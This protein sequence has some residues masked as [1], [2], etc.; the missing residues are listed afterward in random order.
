M[1]HDKGNTSEYLT[2][3]TI[4]PWGGVDKRKEGVARLE[5][6]HACAVFFPVPPRVFA[7]VHGAFSVGGSVSGT[8]TA[9]RGSSTPN[10]RSQNINSNRPSP[11]FLNPIS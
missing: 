3:T 7:L 9:Q 2:P 10:L 4:L 8:N 11:R 6:A 5:F 1:G